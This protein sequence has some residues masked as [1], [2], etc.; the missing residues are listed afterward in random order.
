[1]PGSQA[2]F[3]ERARGHR[4]AS[5]TVQRIFADPE[6]IRWRLGW[7]LSPGV[8]A[9]AVQALADVLKAAVTSRLGYCPLIGLSSERCSTFAKYSPELGRGR[10]PHRSHQSGLCSARR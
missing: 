5:P 6:M 8:I 9:G 10:Y 1:V 7:E 4:G 2:R 3:L